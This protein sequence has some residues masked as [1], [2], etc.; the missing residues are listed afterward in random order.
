[1]TNRRKFLTTG[2]AAG[3]AG[4][5]VPAA[6]AAFGRRGSSCAPAPCQPT[7]CCE[8]IY[9]LNLSK[10][11]VPIEGPFPTLVRQAKYGDLIQ[12]VITYMLGLPPPSPE[13]RCAS[14]LVY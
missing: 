8:P 12:V 11:E 5:M 13:P 3:L 1:M 10:P 7:V 9:R 14:I 6:A 2:A 4:L